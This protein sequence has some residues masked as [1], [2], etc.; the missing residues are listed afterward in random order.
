VIENHLPLE[1]QKAA[2]IYGFKLWRSPGGESVFSVANDQ[3]RTG[4]YM[5]WLEVDGDP[6]RPRI[7]IELNVA[8]VIIARTTCA[9]ADLL[10]AKL[11]DGLAKRTQ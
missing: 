10:K 4:I 6:D 3:C 5:F 9:L 11:K 2:E 1:I 8:D 7:A